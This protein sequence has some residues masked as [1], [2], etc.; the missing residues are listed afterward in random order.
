MQLIWLGTLL[1][2][3]LPIVRFWGRGSLLTLLMLLMMRVAT[4]LG[5]HRGLLSWVL[6]KAKPNCYLVV[7]LFV[8]KSS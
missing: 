3:S 4:L 6:S 1:F 8:A 7:L 5:V 2:D